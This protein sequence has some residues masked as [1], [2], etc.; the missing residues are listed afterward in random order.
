MNKSIPKQFIAGSCYSYILSSK[1]E[2]LIIDSHI[3][4]LDEYRL[5]KQ[6]QPHA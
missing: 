6:E 3:S 5:F 2:T 4:L 1:N